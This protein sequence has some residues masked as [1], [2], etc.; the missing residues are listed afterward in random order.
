[1]RVAFWRELWAKA[2]QEYREGLHEGLLARTFAEA[3]GDEAKAKAA[4]LRNRRTIP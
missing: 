1:M 2:L 4:H 3:D